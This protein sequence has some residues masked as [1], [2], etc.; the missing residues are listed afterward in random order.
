MARFIP[1]ARSILVVPAVALCMSGCVGAV[2][3]A[4]SAS[5]KPDPGQI[6]QNADEN[7]DGVVTRAEFADARNKMFSR[8]DRNG[9]GFLSKEDA[10]HG[11][12]AQRGG[13]GNGMA[14]MMTLFDKDGDG[15]ISRDEFVNGP[16]LSFDRADSNHDGT[17]DAGELKAFRAAIAARGAP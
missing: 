7:G 9:D 15:R 3:R 14:E 12:L 17:I 13:A 4:A 1:F 10:P 5:R 2:A 16:A 6:L 8:L 11:L